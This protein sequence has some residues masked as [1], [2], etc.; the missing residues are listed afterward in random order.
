[1]TDETRL[2]NVTHGP[3]AGG[4]LTLP[5]GEAESAIS[6][7][8]AVDPFAEKPPRFEWEGPPPETLTDEQRKQLRERDE[9]KQLSDEER[10]KVI[11][12]AEQAAKKLRGEDEESVKK[13]HEEQQR[14]MTAG[15]SHGGSY[16]TRQAQ[17]QQPQPQPPQAHRKQTPT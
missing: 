12:K 15:Q 6:E 14:A 17:P 8:W 10:S 9:P 4:R 13:R 5:K 1:M 2:V 7:G 3:Y 16:E 11:E